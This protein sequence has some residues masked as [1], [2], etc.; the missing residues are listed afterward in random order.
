MTYTADDIFIREI[1]GGIWFMT[2]FWL[3]VACIAFVIRQTRRGR[4]RDEEIIIGALGLV[5][6]FSGSTLRGFITWMQFFYAGNRL[7]CVAGDIDCATRWDPGPW[8]ATW[9]LY[10]LSVLLN[11]FGAAVCIWALSSVRWRAIFTVCAVMGAVILPSFV[12]W[13]K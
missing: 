10:G 3:T 1:G 2:S 12:R 9:P 6:Y 13:I 8:I 5:S 7:D 11:I 4:R